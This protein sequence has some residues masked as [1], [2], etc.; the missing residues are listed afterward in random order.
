MFVREGLR[1]IGRRARRRRGE[2]DSRDKKVER[3]AAC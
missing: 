2:R 1:R 3:Y